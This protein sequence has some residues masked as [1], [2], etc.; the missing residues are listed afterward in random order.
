MIF[1]AVPAVGPVRG[2]TV[3]H[4]ARVFSGICPDPE[5]SCFVNPKVSQ[6]RFVNIVLFFFVDP[7][8]MYIRGTG[9]DGD[10]RRQKLLKHPQNQYSIERACHKLSETPSH[11]LIGAVG[12]LHHHFEYTTRA[13]PV[14]TGSG[15]TWPDREPHQGGENPRSGSKFCP[16]ALIPPPPDEALWS[17]L[18]APRPVWAGKST[19]SVLRVMV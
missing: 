19:C 9:G 1:Q 18:A 14:Q 4:T 12:G 15:W 17:S 3:G 10:F 13:F 11:A 16:G 8:G 7:E 6:I 5:K 2:V